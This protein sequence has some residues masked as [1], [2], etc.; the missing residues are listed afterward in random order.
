ME[1][2]YYEWV[3][4]HIDDEGD[5]IDGFHGQT[6]AEVADWLQAV[7]EGCTADFGLIRNQHVH[8]QLERSYAY[9][10]DGE[11]PD[12]FDDGRKV[13]KRFLAEYAKWRVPA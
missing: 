10:A 4:E 11:L 6:L 12:E 1:G 2:T 7:P 13:P 8:W 9:V 3:V 5:I